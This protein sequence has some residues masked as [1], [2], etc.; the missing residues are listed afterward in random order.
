M[1]D[2]TEKVSKAKKTA[3]PKKMSRLMESALDMVK[4]L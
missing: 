4:G 1:K 3:K 2:V